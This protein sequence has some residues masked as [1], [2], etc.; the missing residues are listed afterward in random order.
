VGSEIADSAIQGQVAN[1]TLRAI[2]AQKW[3]AAKEMPRRYGDHLNVEANI[4]V[5]DIEQ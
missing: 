5:I 2:D 3:L 1:A 4:A